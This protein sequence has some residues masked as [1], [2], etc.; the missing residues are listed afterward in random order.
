M[1]FEEV[2]DVEVEVVSMVEVV[3]GTDVEVVDVAEVVEET[4][5]GPQFPGVTTLSSRVMAAVMS[6]N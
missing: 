6:H 2:A 5:T 3:D 1:D 4:V